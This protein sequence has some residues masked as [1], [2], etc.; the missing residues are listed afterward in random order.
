MGC[1]YGLNGEPVEW[2]DGEQ[3]TQEQVNSGA[4]HSGMRIKRVVFDG[5]KVELIDFC[6][7]HS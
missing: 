1:L 4:I 6:L 5:D 7:A 2:P 3:V